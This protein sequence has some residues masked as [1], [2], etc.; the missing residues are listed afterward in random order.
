[1][2]TIV[3]FDNTEQ[4][5]DSSDWG[6]TVLFTSFLYSRMLVNFVSYLVNTVFFELGMFSGFDSFVLGTPYMKNWNMY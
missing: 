6:L 4:C 5:L 3:K 2:F 1:M